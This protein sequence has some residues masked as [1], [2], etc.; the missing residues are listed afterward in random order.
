MSA[1][2][3]FIFVIQIVFMLIY[4]VVPFPVDAILSLYNLANEYI[5]ITICK[6]FIYFAVN[7]LGQLLPTATNG[8]FY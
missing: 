6:M 2:F 4:Y 7:I 8:R 5:F 3:L 1:S